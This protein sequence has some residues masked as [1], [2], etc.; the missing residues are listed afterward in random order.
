MHRHQR[1]EPPPPKRKI[2]EAFAM[3]TARPLHAVTKPSLPL[4]MLK[5]N[6]RTTV[7]PLDFATGK[8]LNSDSPVLLDLASVAYMRDFV[9]R[10][11]PWANGLDDFFSDP[12]KASE[13]RAMVG[14][15]VATDFADTLSA[16][17][18]NCESQKAEDSLLFSSPWRMYSDRAATKWL[19]A[20]DG[21]EY[22]WR[23]GTAFHS[24]QPFIP[25]QGWRPCDPRF[26]HAICYAIDSTPFDT[27]NEVIRTSE[28]KTIVFLALANHIKAEYNHLDSF[29]VTVISFWDHDVRIVQGLVNLRTRNID[30]RVSPVQHFPRGIRLQDG[31]VDPRFLTLLS[32][33]CGKVNPLP[34]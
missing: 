7:T 30:L 5:N 12:P 22:I 26:P 33:N 8:P 9:S 4:A 16:W 15:R 14:Y 19:G 18:E 11:K 6:F 29:G 20:H 13:T 34:K 3:H 1:T 21:D 28:F 31:S 25:G 10:G 24:L 23:C 17:V 32:Y 27:K 2:P